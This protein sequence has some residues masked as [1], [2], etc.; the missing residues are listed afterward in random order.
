MAQIKDLILLIEA[1]LSLART[2]I[3]EL[4]KGIG[5]AKAGK[6]KAKILLEMVEATLTEFEPITDS[7]KSKIIKIVNKFAEIYINVKNALGL[8]KK[9]EN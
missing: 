9:S 8:F 3:D 5:I 7:I 2:L 1:V 4:E 6:E